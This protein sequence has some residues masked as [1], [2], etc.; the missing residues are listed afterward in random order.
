MF[1][2]P[3]GAQLRIRTTVYSSGT[4]AGTLTLSSLPTPASENVV[5]IGTNASSGDGTLVFQLTDGN[6]NRP[7]TTAGHLYNGSGWDRQRSVS[8]LT[9]LSSAARTTTTNSGDQTNY[10]HRGMLLIVDVSS[11]GTGSISPSIQVKDSISSNY[12]TIWTATTA[13]T[14]N[15]TYVYALYP[16]AAS[17]ASYAEAVQIIVGRTWRLAMV[18]NNANSVTYSASA[19]MV[20]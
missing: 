20:L 15:G 13:L 14:A 2:I 12:K 8:A 17:V 7:V 11:A 18:A 16:G 4:V 10:N 5:I 3:V 9:V 6:N 19:D 1:A